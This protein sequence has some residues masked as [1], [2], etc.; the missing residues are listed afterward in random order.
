MLLL[1]LVVSRFLLP[2][3]LDEYLS[4]RL[5]GDEHPYYLEVLGKEGE[6]GQHLIFL[7][8]K[9]GEYRVLCDDFY[10]PT[11]RREKI[12]TVRHCYLDW[13]LDDEIDAEFHGEGILEDSAFFGLSQGTEP[14][15]Q[16]RF[17]PLS[18]KGGSFSL[19]TINCLKGDWEHEN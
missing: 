2:N 13:D 4:H 9:R 14:I 17:S 1:F 18:G 12:P 19:I 16:I 8:E 11:G 5:W 6:P 10:S 15:R 7:F 3:P